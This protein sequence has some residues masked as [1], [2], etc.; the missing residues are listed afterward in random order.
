MVQQKSKELEAK[1]AP[2]QYAVGV[3]SGSKKLIAAVRTFLS[4]GES[5]KQRVLLSLDAKN[6]F[7]SM[8]RQAILEGVDRLIP[9]LTQYFL[10][11]YGEPAE[12]WSHHEKGYTCKVLSQEGA[13]Q[14]GSEGPA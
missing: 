14:G 2:C 11:W 3:A 10:Q 7:N 1:L 9:D 4:A 13:Q 12:L 5:D 8:S 6:A